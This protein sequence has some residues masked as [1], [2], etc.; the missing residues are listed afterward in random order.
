M[1]SID[2]AKETAEY[3]PRMNANLFNNLFGFY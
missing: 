1:Q 2:D 3:Y